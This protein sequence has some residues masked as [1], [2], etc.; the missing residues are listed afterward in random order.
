M[1]TAHKF[2]SR[3]KA[4]AWAM[5]Y[6]TKRFPEWQVLT[7]QAPNLGRSYYVV[8]LVAADGRFATENDYNRRA[9][10]EDKVPTE[11]KP[12]AQSRYLRPGPVDVPHCL[13][14]H[15]GYLCTRAVGHLGDHAAHTPSSEMVTRWRRS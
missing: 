1:K 7:V 3:S 12:P 13:A 5:R 6:A 11:P 2:V 14:Q 10:D 15:T 9:F 4:S 8:L